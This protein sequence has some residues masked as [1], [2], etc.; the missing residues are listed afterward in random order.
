MKPSCPVA[1]VEVDTSATCTSVVTFG[2][3][4]AAV[5][6][7]FLNRLVI[8]GDG[9]RENDDVLD[10]VE[11]SSC[12]SLSLRSQLFLGVK[13]PESVFN[14]W[15]FSLLPTTAAQISA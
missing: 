7:P 8:C 4:G 1:V 11:G 6:E 15:A 9:K 10:G 3:I 12:K 13:D 5:I 14:G 2:G